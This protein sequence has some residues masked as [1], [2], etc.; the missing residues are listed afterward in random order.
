M[1]LCK[2]CSCFFFAY[3]EEPFF[4]TALYHPSHLPACFHSGYDDLCNRDL[5]RGRSCFN[6]SVRNKIL[7]YSAANVQQ[8]DW[9]AN[10]G[11]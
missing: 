6:Y 10:Q 1:C 7:I 8:R 4:G 9:W 3:L 5:A 2:R 11:I